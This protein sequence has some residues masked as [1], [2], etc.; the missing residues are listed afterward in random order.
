MKRMILVASALMA[1]CPMASAQEVETLVEP[2]PGQPDYAALM[3]EAAWDWRPGDL[4][5]LNGLNE[6]DEL[7]RQ[8]E[9][10]EWASVGILRPSSGDPRVVFV[11]DRDGVTEVML[12]ELTEMRSD[13]GYAVYRVRG[14]EAKGLG[15]LTSYS[16][17][18]AYGRP[19]DPLMLFGNGQFYN[20]E[21]PFEAAMS[22]GHVIAEPRRLGDFADPDSPMVKA[23]LSGWREHPYCVAALSAEDCWQVVQ[24]IAVVTPGALLSS[25]KLER[26]YPD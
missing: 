12:S 6:F 17:F 19:F 18:S 10:G 21:L 14:A 15:F 4:I 16:L 26:I 5:F 13:D 8:A 23:I 22:E 1:L 9:G 2:E 25:G 3:A 20:A 7:V 24:D 11:D